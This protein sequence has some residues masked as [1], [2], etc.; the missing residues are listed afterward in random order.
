M[1]RLNP[2]R[3]HAALRGEAG[4]GALSALRA[5]MPAVPPNL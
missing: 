1:N 2:I 5:G 4:I 3:L